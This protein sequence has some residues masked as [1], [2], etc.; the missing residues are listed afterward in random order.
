MCKPEDGWDKGREEG[1]G[2]WKMS[3]W[4]LP[5]TTEWIQVPCAET[6]N[7]RGEARLGKKESYSILNMF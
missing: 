3:P 6:G 1:E 7:P 5:W 2:Q 4:L